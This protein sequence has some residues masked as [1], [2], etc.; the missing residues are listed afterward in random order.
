LEQGRSKSKFLG[1]IVLGEFDT[2]CGRRGVQYVHC[3]MHK[4]IMVKRGG[5]RKTHKVCKTRKFYEIR[6]EF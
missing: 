6:G 3:V 5:K 4:C 2:E 1:L